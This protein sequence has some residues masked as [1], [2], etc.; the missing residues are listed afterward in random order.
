M[1]IDDGVATSR[2]GHRPPRSG[3]ADHHL[4]ETLGQRDYGAKSKSVLTAESQHAC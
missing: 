4:G 1:R 3:W 2:E